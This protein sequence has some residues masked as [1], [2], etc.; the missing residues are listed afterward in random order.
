[1]SPHP[2]SGRDG[3][4]LP[5]LIGHIVTGLLAVVMAPLRFVRWLAE[6]LTWWSA[7]SRRRVMATVLAST[8]VAGALLTRTSALELRYQHAPMERAQ[9]AE[10]SYMPPSQVLR[11]LSLDHRGFF[12]DMLFT[13]ANIY[14]ISHLF[15]DRIYDWLDVYVEA[16]LALDPDNPRVYEWAS[17]SVKYG[18]MISDESLEHSNDYA[19]RGIERFPDHWRFYF[20]I[21]F[22]YYIEWKHEDEA[23]RQAMQEK[24]LPYFSVA[25]SLP[26]SQLDPNFVTE[27][28]LQRNEVSMALFHAYLRYWESSERERTA[29]RGRITR[30]QSDA[31]AQRLVEIEE[32]WKRAYGYMPF[33]LFEA[34]GPEHDGLGP[35]DWAETGWTQ[36]R[37]G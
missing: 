10:A 32:R 9:S 31:A 7:N 20:D 37:G 11:A 24:A 27:I 16:I 14:F 18:Q 2:R 25:A 19:R 12:A 8:L 13:R 33:G 23:E 1:M 3:A 4:S 6:W 29:L 26:G 15:S 34:L 21:G 35:V 17:Q 5:G 36:E 30:Y 22:N 28:Y